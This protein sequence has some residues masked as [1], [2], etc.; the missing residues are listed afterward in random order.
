MLISHFYAILGML[1][2][3]VTLYE[4]HKWFYISLDGEVEKFTSRQQLL[5]EEGK[6]FQKKNDFVIVVGQ[7]LLSSIP[8]P[9]E[10]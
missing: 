5:A 8:A 6:V 7:S 3:A 10:I 1:G 9:H 4:K 2:W